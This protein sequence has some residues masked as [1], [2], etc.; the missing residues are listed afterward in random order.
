MPWYQRP[1]PGALYVIGLIPAVW[2]FYLG[3]VDQLGADPMKVL[4]RDLGLWALKFL[5]SASRSRRCGG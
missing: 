1:R 5:V 4:E 3:V 2:T